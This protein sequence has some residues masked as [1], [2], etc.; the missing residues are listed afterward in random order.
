[1]NKLN[2]EVFLVV[3][4]VKGWFAGGVVNFVFPDDEHVVVGAILV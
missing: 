4:S 1:M 3:L 2:L